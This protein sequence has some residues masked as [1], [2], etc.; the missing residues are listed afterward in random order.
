MKILKTPYLSNIL[1]FASILLLSFIFY[2][3][4]LKNKYNLD[5]NYVIVDQP[6]TNQGIKAIPKIFTSHYINKGQESHSYRPVT[7]SVFALEYELFGAKPAISH[8]FNVLLYALCCFLVFRLILCLRPQEDNTIMALCAAVLFLILPVHSEV[9][10]NVK[11][12]DE[13]LSFAFAVGACIQFLKYGKTRSLKF[14]AFGFLLLTASILSKKTSFT[15][16]AV[17]PVMLL[18]FTDIKRK[19]L[20]IIVSSFL[21][22]FVGLRY[23]RILLVQNTSVVREI[24][25]FENPLFD[26]NQYSFFDRIPAAIA[27]FGNYVQLLIHPKELISYYGYNQVEIGAWSDGSIW[28]ILLLIIGILVAVVRLW[29]TRPLLVFGLIWFCVTI[30]MFSN[31]IKP[32]VG[33]IAERFVFLPSVGFVLVIAYLLS[34][35]LKTAFFQKQL[36]R[37]GMVVVLLGIV[38]FNGVKVNH[39][40]ADWYNFKTLMETDVSVASNSAKLHAL[41][42]NHLFKEIRAETD[43]NQRSQLT[44]K[45]LN[46]YQRCITIYPGYYK[47]WNN[48]GSLVL[49]EYSDYELALTYYENAIFYKPDYKDALFG[50]GYANEMLGNYGEA[51]NYYG[52]LIAIDGNHL[53]VAGRVLNIQ[54]L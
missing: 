29:K 27:T 50:A 44:L 51:L 5:D 53:N 47:T 9:V 25:Y 36:P 31:L 52:K 34:Q 37:L 41:L 13:L 35:L 16:F 28:F 46:L 26:S 12:R 32:V 15:L 23:F 43:Y 33:I 39:R 3:S 45:T 10:N 20:L 40:N 30:S 21:G 6:L 38:L 7:L 17:I 22:L 48:M 14:V 49:N 42:A 24:K 8:V 2:G 18:L 1:A 19:E 4:S 54:N 11:C